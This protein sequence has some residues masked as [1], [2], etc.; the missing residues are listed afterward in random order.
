MVQ[1]TTRVFAARFFE[2]PQFLGLGLTNSMQNLSLE[3]ISLYDPFQRELYCR[4]INVRVM[5]AEGCIPLSV[6]FHHFE[7]T[8]SNHEDYIVHG[9]NKPPSNKN[10]KTWVLSWNT[11]IVHDGYGDGSHCRNLGWKFILESGTKLVKWIIFEGLI[12]CFQG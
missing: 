11:S 8:F 3:G 9:Q 2:I 5:K 7:S 12:A 1:T 6:V 4:W 10:R